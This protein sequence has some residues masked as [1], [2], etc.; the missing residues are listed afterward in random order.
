MQKRR[1]FLA[2]LSC[3]LW[4]TGFA[5][6]AITGIVKDVTGEPLIGVS[7]MIKGSNSGTVTDMDGRFNLQSV[8]SS[9]QLQ[10]SYIGYLTQTVKVGNSTNFNITL[11]E[12]NASLDEVVVIGYQTVKRRDLTGSVASVNNKQLT[13]APVADVAQALQG[14]LAGV[15]IVAQD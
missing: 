3:M 4:L 10:F 6:N 1:I 7:V 2:I 5:Q 13:A 11:S 14:K 15:N 8:P 9:A 12:D